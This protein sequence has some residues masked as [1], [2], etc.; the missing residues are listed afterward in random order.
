MILALNHPRYK[1]NKQRV[2]SKQTNKEPQQLTKNN[3]HCKFGN[4]ANKHFKKL[5]SWKMMALF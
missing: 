1:P 4:H 2:E 5:S 3:K